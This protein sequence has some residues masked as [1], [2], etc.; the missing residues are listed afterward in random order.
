VRDGDV[1]TLRSRALM[2]EAQLSCKSF[3]SRT[4]CPAAAAAVATR[5]QHFAIRQHLQTLRLRKT[6]SCCNCITLLRYT[7]MRTRMMR[8]PETQATVVLKS[9]DADC[10]ALHHQQT[11]LATRAAR[12][13]GAN[14]R[15]TCASAWPR[16]SPMILNM[17]MRVATE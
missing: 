10:L 1:V 9:Y 7:L 11:Y 5:V 16:C 2:I 3:L 17:L 15:R 6:A 8:S 4:A 14:V 13:C 12:V